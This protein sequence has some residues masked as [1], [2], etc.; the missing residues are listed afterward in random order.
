MRV[1][2]LLVEV[3]FY[4][5]LGPNDLRLGVSSQDQKCRTCGETKECQGHF[6]HIKL[7]E[8]VYHYGFLKYIEKILRCV[9]H[10]CY[11]LKAA[12]TPSQVHI[13]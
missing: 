9:C 11:R 8:P 2:N 3:F 13:I 12:T 7:S 4:V 10:R 1:L 5:K 6:G